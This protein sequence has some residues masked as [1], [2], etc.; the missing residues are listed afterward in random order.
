MMVFP[1][2]IA[3][4]YGLT[5][6]AGAILVSAVFSMVYHCDEENILCLLADIVGVI[7]LLTTMLLVLWKSND[8][9]TPMNGI[10]CV[11]FSIALVYYILAGD[12][13][14]EE[15]DNCHTAWHL[16]GSYAV[17]ALVYS[18]A[19]S[20]VLTKNKSVLCTSPLK[21][22]IQPLPSIE[23]RILLQTQ[24]ETKPII[25]RNIH[26]LARPPG[27]Q[28]SEIEDVVAYCSRRAL[29]MINHFR[30]H[31]GLHHH[32]TSLASPDGVVRR[33]PRFST[34]QQIRVG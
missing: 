10:A 7:T 32:K 33:Y 15:Y 9:F 19:N 11:Y 8:F 17:A 28:T 4:K 24:E 23:P 34:V 1:F 13:K 6:I 30:A 29:P 5:H 3:Y 26:R 31:L 16:F 27:A 14:S 21:Q 18:Y 22:W 25:R 12:N 20:T 2:L